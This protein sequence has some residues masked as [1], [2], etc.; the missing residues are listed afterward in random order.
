MPP[1]RRNRLV[2]TSLLTPGGKNRRSPLLPHVT[3]DGK[4]AVSASHL[5]RIAQKCLKNGLLAGSVPAQSQ[6]PQ[7]GRRS[8]CSR[9]SVHSRRAHLFVTHAHVRA[10]PTRPTRTC[11]PAM[12][13]CA[14]T[15][16][17]GAFEDL[18]SSSVQ[19]TGEKRRDNHS[20]HGRNAL[21]SGR[22]WRACERV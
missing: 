21:R 7:V 6:H 2:A 14:S 8:I 22:V 10:D 12:R 13:P 5:L 1:S 15:T 3:P 4:N 16:R 9:S 18:P 17:S 20:S 11:A 19:K